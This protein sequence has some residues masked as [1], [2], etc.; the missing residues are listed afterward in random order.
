MLFYVTTWYKDAE[1]LSVW[2]LKWS[3]CT[4][5][6][7]V[8]LAI[9]RESNTYGAA[10]Q[11]GRR[12]RNPMRTLEEAVLQCVCFVYHTA[13]GRVPETQRA[14][15]AT[16][17]TLFLC[18][19]PSSRCTMNRNLNA[20]RQCDFVNRMWLYCIA[21]EW[22]SRKFVLWNFC[23]NAALLQTGDWCVSASLIFAHSLGS[24]SADWPWR[25]RQ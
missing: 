8:C 24:S 1:T 5:K 23:G 7:Q 2:C 9:P 15:V 10:G 20:V 25:W 17:L 12:F 13:G 18:H 16:V 19:V 4:R 3:G 6:G 22:T 14:C 11:C 21:S